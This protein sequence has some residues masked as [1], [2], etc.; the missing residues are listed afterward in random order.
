MDIQKELKQL[1]AA[2]QKLRNKYGKRFQRFYSTCINNITANDRIIRDAEKANT[3]Q[4]K[5]VE[6]ATKA[7]Q[8][9][10]FKY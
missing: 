7:M 5:N 10:D 9:I 4:K 8:S 6:A 1:D 3:E 2:Q